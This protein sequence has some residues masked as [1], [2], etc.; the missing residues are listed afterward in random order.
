MVRVLGIHGSPRKQGNSDLLLQR[1]LDGA[2]RA[3][4][5]VSSLRAADL[6]LSGCRE[7][8]GCDATGTCIVDDEMQKVY[9][10]LAAADRI[11]LGLGIAGLS[12]RTEEGETVRLMLPGQRVVLYVFPMGRGFGMTEVTPNVRML[13]VVDD[14]KSGVWSIDSKLVYVPFERL[15]LLNNMEAERDADDL[16]KS[17]A[18]SSRNWLTWRWPGQ[19]LGI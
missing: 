16:S 8:G 9:P 14:A 5:E 19:Y 6:S 13:T 7:C 12:F 10:R 15:Q 18:G 2:Q 11:I 3:G 1:A 17:P 4:A